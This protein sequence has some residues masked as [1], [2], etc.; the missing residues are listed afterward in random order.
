LVFHTEINVDQVGDNDL[1][2]LQVSINGKIYKNLKLKR[3]LNKVSF[4]F[5]IK[6][7]KLW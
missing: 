7:P 3:E 1:E 6:K 2:K 4:P 5:E